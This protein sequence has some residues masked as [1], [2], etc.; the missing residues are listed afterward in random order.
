MDRSPQDPNP[1]DPSDGPRP[2]APSGTPEPAHPG[3]PRPAE[4]DA[5]ASPL[6]FPVETS[7]SATGDLFGPADPEAVKPPA[8]RPAAAGSPLAFPVEAPRPDPAGALPV[9]APQPPLSLSDSQSP[10]TEPVPVAILPGS[11]PAAPQAPAETP[12]PEP[13]KPATGPPRVLAPLLVVLGALLVL[14]A[15]FLPLLRIEQHVTPQQTFFTP[16]LVFTQSA[17]SSQVSAEGNYSIDQPAAPVGIPIV[18]AVAVLAAA[19]VFSF[20]RR[21]GRLG[22]RLTVIGASFA[23]G[24]AAT[25][26][27]SA[28]GF[29]SGLGDEGLDVSLGLGLWSLILG[30][31]L[32]V[33]SAVLGHLTPAEPSPAWADPGAAYADTPTPPSGIA[34]T[35][36]P[37]EDP[38][39]R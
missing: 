32:A 1:P 16:K 6:A 39:R 13:P 15:S 28:F 36:L 30:V 29:S 5:S 26:G 21:S 10:P 8:E 2:A 35:V 7:G 22:A 25:I 23:A 38:E 11:P 24:V 4:P 33:A 37:P 9:G 17:W 34:I 14:G 3:S 12:A 20:T 19:A 27:M 18:I 31:V